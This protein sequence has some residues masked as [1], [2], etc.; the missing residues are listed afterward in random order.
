MCKQ[1]NRLIT[2]Q[3]WVMGRGLPWVIGSE[4]SPVGQ[5][6]KTLND[7]FTNFYLHF[8]LSTCLLYLE[9]RGRARRRRVRPRD[10]PRRVDRRP[11]PHVAFHGNPSGPPLAVDVACWLG[12]AAVAE[13]KNCMLV[14]I[15]YFSSQSFFLFFFFFLLATGC[16][17][18]PFFSLFHFFPLTP[19]SFFSPS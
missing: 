4:K 2:F 11:Y 7:N 14:Q 16:N 19:N 17:F 15:L 13:N 8:F 18:P 6:V 5:R 3:I 1:R 12:P 9:R 10:R